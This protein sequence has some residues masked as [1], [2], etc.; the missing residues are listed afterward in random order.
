MLMLLSAS[1]CVAQETPRPSVRDRPLVE[2]SFA[3]ASLRA[4]EDGTPG[5]RPAERPALAELFRHV[6]RID[7]QTRDQA[8]RRLIEKRREVVGGEGGPIAP[9]VDLAAHPADYRGRPVR[10]WG[11]VRSVAHRSAGDELPEHYEVALVPS[12]GARSRV[13]LL[14]ATLPGE[15]SPGEGLHV[16][17]LATAWLFKLAASESAPESERRAEELVPLFVADELVPFGTT[18]AE[19]ILEEVHPRTY[20]VHADERDAYLQ[21]LLQARLVGTAELES[22]AREFLGERIAAMRSRKTPE[23]YERFLDAFKNSDAYRGRPVTFRGHARRIVAVDVEENE[24]GID[25]LYEV[26]L[27]TPDSQGHPLVVACTSIPA[28]IPTGAD[29]VPA[30]ET[31]SV[32]GYFFKM[33]GYG[34]RDTNRIAPLIVAERLEWTPE[35]VGWATPYWLWLI[36]AAVLLV[37]GYIVLRG[38]REERAFREDR[39]K[40]TPRDEPPEFDRGPDG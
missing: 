40:R 31:V 3:G 32:T 17:A 25:S 24:Y 11:H 36:G 30:V 13:V 2:A 21:A 5:I 27:Y 29:L 37:L 9:L 34:A 16:P 26:W 20:L 22:A 7:E 35:P 33:C 39:A 10:V 18:L 15:L 19:S 23:T 14:L 38:R 1:R 4:V 28:G 6:S 12:G 8:V